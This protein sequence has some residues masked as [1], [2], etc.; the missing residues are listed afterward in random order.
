MNKYAKAGVV[1][2]LALFGAGCDSFIQGPGLTENPN[3]PTTGTLQQQMIAVQAAMAVQYEGQLA[4]TAGM[5][6]QQIIGSNNQQLTQGTQYNTLESDVSGFMSRFYTGGGLIGLRNIQVAANA[7]GD[8]FFEGMAKIWEGFAMGTATSLW[9]DLPY[10][11]ALNPAILTPKLDKQEDIYAEV[12]KRLDEGIVLMQGASATGNCEVADLMYCAT[13]STRATQIARWIA[14]ANTMKAR[15][16]LDL[17]ERNGNAAYTLALAAANKGILEAPTT[18]AQAMNG[19]AVGDFRTFHGSTQ[20]VDGN[21]WGEFLGQRQDI[22][23]GNVLVSILKARTDPRLTAYFDLNAT[24]SVLGMD[25][26][27]KVVGVGAASVINLVTRRAFPFR[28]PLVTWAE[29][30]L[31]IAEASFKL[32]NATGALGNVNAVRAAVGLPALPGPATMDDI[33]T[34]KYIAMFQN[35][36]AWSDFKRTCLPLIKPFGA[37]T[38]VPGRLPYGSAERTNNPN[39][40]LPSAFPTGTTGVS[41]QRNWNDPIACPRPA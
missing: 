17:V 21:I 27:A 9:G 24:G 5:F 23:A 18:A 25:E 28:Q 8:K 13:A 19:Q 30:Q 1:L 34:E 33:M 10:S 14:A 4:R 41:A 40:P 29:N 35:I 36:S 15:F 6:T 37:A 11:E 22:V 38:E 7:A 3:S 20:D 31:I 26:N 39:L 12:Q 2:S 16:Y 32:G